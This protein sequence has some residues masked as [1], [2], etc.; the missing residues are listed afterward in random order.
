MV[1]CRVHPGVII[2]LGFRAS[3]VPRSRAD[4]GCHHEEVAC[5]CERASSP[6]PRA[7]KAH[8]SPRCRERLFGSLRSVKLFFGVFEKKERFLARR[9]SA[10]GLPC[11]AAR[12][13]SPSGPSA[14]P[15][16]RFARIH[17]IF[18][19]EEKKEKKTRSPSCLCLCLCFRAHS[20]QSFPV[21][22][23]LRRVGVGHRWRITVGA[24]A[25]ELKGDRETL[26]EWDRSKSRQ[27]K[28]ALA[29]RL[30]LRASRPLGAPAS[31]LENSSGRGG[32]S[33][34]NSSGRLDEASPPKTRPVTPD[35]RA[36][37][38]ESIR[39]RF[40]ARGR[41]HPRTG[42]RRRRSRRTD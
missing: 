3:E 26:G 6:Q 2:P 35:K 4:A 40:P 28:G 16:T 42:M 36:D 23:E 9:G 21:A 22:L 11:S 30:H 20:P 18:V 32:R 39:T 34:K 1:S 41:A 13:L 38:R 12:R 15:R 10:I 31:R 25:A 19:F 24:D 17:P 7:L 14:C 8:R 5:T 33:L 27:S 37:S 29:S